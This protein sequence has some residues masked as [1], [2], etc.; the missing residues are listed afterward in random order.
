MAVISITKFKTFD[1]YIS[2][3]PPKVKKLMKDLRKAIKQA[4]PEAEEIISYNMPAFKIYGRILVY[5]AAHTKHVGFYPG[6][7][8]V[9]EIFKENLISYETSKGTVKFPF[10][11]PILVSLVKKIVQFRVKENLNKAN[12]KHSASARLKK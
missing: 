3:L 2:A 11:K 6:N 4:A 9:N 1:E 10:E 8:V 12:N 7:Q 5:F